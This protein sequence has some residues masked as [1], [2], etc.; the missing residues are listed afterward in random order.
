[1]PIGEQ[2]CSLKSSPHRTKSILI[3]LITELS[4]VYLKRAKRLFKSNYT[5][6]LSK[7]FA[8]RH[9]QKLGAALPPNKGLG[10][11]CCTVFTPHVKYLWL[12]FTLLTFLICKLTLKYQVSLSQQEYNLLFSILAIKIFPM[13]STFT[14]SCPIGAAIKKANLHLKLSTELPTLKMYLHFSIWLWL[15]LPEFWKFCLGHMHN[16]FTKREFLLLLLNILQ[17]LHSFSQN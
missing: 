9:T 2:Q 11:I 13:R 16:T 10:R 15:S 8:H 4:Q 12:M 14:G 6:L 3:R 7:E 5:W 1:M 17:F